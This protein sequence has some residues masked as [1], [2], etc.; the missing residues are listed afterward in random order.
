MTKMTKRDWFNEMIK[1]VEESAYED[2][3]GAV[4]F[5]THEIELLERKSGKSGM[6]KTQKENVGIMEQ[7]KVALDAVGK[8][9]T[10]SELM[11][12]DP[13]M[14]GYS[15]QKLSALIRQLVKAGEVVRTEDKKKAY[16][17]LAEQYAGAQAPF[18]PVA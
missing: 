15:N 7:I 18:A 1:V 4:E 6:T 5:L 12:A 8:P 14:G 16:F 17:S 13:V 11:A 3:A 2:K 9:V 10:I